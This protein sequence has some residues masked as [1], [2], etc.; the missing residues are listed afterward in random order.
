MFRQF[1]G[2]FPGSMDEGARKLFRLHPVELAALL[3]Q[4]WELRRHDDTPPND[5]PQGHPFRRSNL[6]GLPHYLLKLF[7]CTEDN[8]KDI[9]DSDPQVEA[10]NLP[11]NNPCLEPRD[12]P[13][14]VMWD[15]LIY[16]YMIENTRVY[17]IFR[18]VL[19]E[20]RHGEQ[21]GV[22]IEGAEHWLRNTEELFYKEPAS[23]FIYSLGSFIRPN[24][25]SSRRNAYYRMFGMEL[26]HQGED[27]IPYEK[28]QAANSEFVYIFEEFLREVWLGVINVNNT[29]GS[30]PTDDAEI[31]N[32]AEKLHDMLVTRRLGSNL[33]REEFFF[34]SMMAWFQLTLEFD[35]PIVLSLR[36]EGTS[37]EQRLHKIAQ[38]V[39]LPAHALSKNFFDMADAISRVL[40]Q[41]ETG[42][43]NDPGAVPALYT[44]VS[45][46]PEADIRTIITHWSITTGHDLKARKVTSA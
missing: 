22:P 1:A 10:V 6:P 15:H 31:A 41:I 28:A 43:Y 12:L 36:A 46:G 37:P 4:A 14:C 33:A 9:C 13:R 38:R 17:E 16:A 5:K 34:V 30:N 23:F 32:L 42:I 3:E 18:K 7:A 39:G 29:S 35:S 2:S 19:H 45:G 25:C 20:F 21:L 40:I 27:K 44:R 24:L 8:I 26:N 11:P